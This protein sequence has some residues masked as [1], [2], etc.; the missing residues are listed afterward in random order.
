MKKLY[1]VTLLVSV[2][3]A[4]TVFAE[5]NCPTLTP[6][7]IG[8]AACSTKEKPFTTSPLAAVKFHALTPC[9]AGIWKKKLQGLVKGEK[10]YKP[11]EEE[12]SAGKAT[13]TYALSD[14]WKTALNVRSNE[15]VFE[16]SLPT[17]EHANFWSAPAFSSRCPVIKA[18][19]ID[20]IR[21]GKLEVTRKRTA[22]A[23]DIEYTYETKG[24]DK[25]MLSN[26]KS[27]FAKHPNSSVS[28]GKDALV[29]PFDVTCSYKIHLGGGTNEQEI[30]I[31]GVQAA[32]K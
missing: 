3:G 12:N 24:L 9:P 5:A 15:L 28:A 31:K 2:V 14:T 7:N 1:I 23:K 4:G 18:D 16:V 20:S 22:P 32:K 10:N 6:S 30:K 8:E 25:T 19:L 11:T 21:G 29:T 27:Y 13:C 26:F 17:R